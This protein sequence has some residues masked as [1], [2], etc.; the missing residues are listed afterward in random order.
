MRP[1]PLLVSRALAVSALLTS[2]LCEV[3]L[4][5]DYKISLYAELSGMSVTPM[6]ADT[7]DGVPPKGVVTRRV[8]TRD[9]LGVDHKLSYVVESRDDV[10]VLEHHAGVLGVDCGTPGQLSIRVADP[11]SFL[12]NLPEDADTVLFV[13][14]PGWGC[15]TASWKGA[16]TVGGNTTTSAGSTN[17]TE[18]QS[19]MTLE[20]TED[21]AEL[22]AALA[23]LEPD[24]ESI[25]LRSAALLSSD[26]DTLTFEVQMTTITDLYKAADIQYT[27]AMDPAEEARMAAVEAQARRAAQEAATATAAAAA[28]ATASNATSSSPGRRRRL[29]IA[30]IYAAVRVPDDHPDAGYAPT[31][32]PHK[33]ALRRLQRVKTYS[34]VYS[35]VIDYTY[36]YTND[37]H[38]S[39]NP[40]CVTWMYGTCIWGVSGTFK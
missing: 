18:T 16:S 33:R 24:G 29:N 36:S 30:E 26:D 23:A 31:L 10:V 38:D 39:Y 13:L 20:V 7:V 1:T 2:A 21:E 34:G 6:S 4:S 27:R 5:E 25:F 12:A 28:N 37:A 17:G 19:T 35:G 9:F 8:D 40:V 32:T 14:G 22:V 15:K 3:R 11:P